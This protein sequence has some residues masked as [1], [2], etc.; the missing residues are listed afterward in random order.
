MLRWIHYK[1]E[2]YLC[3]KVGSYHVAICRGEKVEFKK[4]L[5]YRLANWTEFRLRNYLY[6][7]K[8]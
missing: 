7:R 4:T 8:I 5:F 6:P 3:R 2:R 1:L